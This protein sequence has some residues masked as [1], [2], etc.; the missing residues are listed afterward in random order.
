MKRFVFS[1]MLLALLLA[2]CTKHQEIEFA[3]TVTGIRQC[4]AASILD[5]NVGYI[6]KLDYP[7]SV[8]GTIETDD[9]VASGLIVLYEPSRIIRVDDHI[10]GAFYLDDKYSR[11]NCSVHYNDYEL[12]E[13]VFT[14]LHVD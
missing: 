6:V 5:Q 11:A 10:H 13:G 8:G 2:S 3:G 7:D 4:S 14:E 12:P 9:G 1:S